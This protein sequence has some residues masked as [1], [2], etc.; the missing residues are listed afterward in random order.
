M[1]VTGVATTPDLRP[2][3][4]LYGFS[5]SCLI[6]LAGTN[7]IKEVARMGVIVLSL[8][9]GEAVAVSSVDVMLAGGQTV[10]GCLQSAEVPLC[11][12]RD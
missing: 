9:L 5:F 4:S 11:L 1:L 6:A 3:F 7:V 12:Q 2:I 10:H 8:I